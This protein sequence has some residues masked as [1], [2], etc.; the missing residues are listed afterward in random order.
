MTESNAELEREEPRLRIEPGKFVVVG[1]G[2]R[3]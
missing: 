3:Q 1:Q 2:K